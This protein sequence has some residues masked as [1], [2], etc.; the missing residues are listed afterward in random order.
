M[1]WTWEWNI[2]GPAQKSVRLS[3]ILRDGLPKI[4]VVKSHRESIY[5]LLIYHTQMLHVWNI[6]LHKVKPNV[7]KYPIY[8]EFGIQF[9]IPI[10]I[11]QLK[12]RLNIY[13]TVTLILWENG[14]KPS[15]T[16]HISY[17]LTFG[18]MVG[19]YQLQVAF[20]FLHC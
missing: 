16:Y 4:Q 6:Y 19:T 11:N 13:Q 18:S 14:S 17:L 5:G 20:F 12:G 2:V 3:D 1:E 15:S 9:T 8:G 10:N 7:G